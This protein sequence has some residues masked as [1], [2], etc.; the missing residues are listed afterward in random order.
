MFT[1]CSKRLIKYD[2]LIAEAMLHIEFLLTM[3][4]PL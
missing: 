1:D 2:V 4:Y 3:G